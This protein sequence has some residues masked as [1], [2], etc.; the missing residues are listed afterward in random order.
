MTQPP[1]G[2]P[3]NPWQSPPGGEYPPTQPASPPQP[4]YQPPP[5]PVYQPP[6]YPPAAPP[7]SA[8]P[9]P[10]SAPPY[11]ASVPPT[12]QPTSGYPQPGYPPPYP[13]APQ[14]PSAPPYP[15]SAPPYPGS[16]P[17]AGFP[18]YFG[19]P[20][21]PRRRRGLLITVIVLVAVVVLGGGGF[22]IFY[23]FNRNSDGVGKS[24]PTAAAE[25][26]LQAI[27]VDQDATKAAP[28]VCSAARDKKKLAAKIDQ[29]KQQNQQYESPKYTWSAFKTE[30]SAGDHAV[31]STTVTLLTANVQKA[32]QKLRLT[33]IKSN[34]W[35]VCDVQQA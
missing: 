14:Y 11:P 30:T 5:G 1:P 2:Y 6:G 31:V 22:G 27:Y 10:G 9:Y 18:P 19:P 23:L 15:G 28:L 29:I 24:S 34:G 4:V 35:F 25:S 3:G 26:F 20:A 7:E 17:P 12:E 32:T 16:A 21:P 13:G 8:P 33:V